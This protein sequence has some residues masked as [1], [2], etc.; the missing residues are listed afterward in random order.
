MKKMLFLSVAALAAV[1][2]IMSA[3]TKDN[4]PASV[5]DGSP[6]LV[7]VNGED[8]TADEFRSEAESLSP[9]A[10]QILA[11]EETKNKLLDNLVSRKLL[12]QQ[13]RKDGYE[14]DPEVVKRIGEVMDNLLLGYYVKREIFDKA[15]VSDQQVREYFDGSKDVLGSAR[16]S[17]IQVGSEE[18]AEE[19]IV[20]Y[21]SGASFNALAR[22]YS[23]DAKTKASGGDL[24]FLSWSQFGSAELRAAAFDT[25]LGEVGNVVKSS[26]AYHV[27]KVTD[28]KPAKAEDFDKL[29]D[30]LK[31]H[32]LERRK[33]EF[34][35]T[36]V[37]SLKSGAL[38]TRNELA[39]K[40]LSS[41]G[42]AAEPQ[43]LGR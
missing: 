31:E 14:K 42:Q 41:S 8:I 25:P 38:I 40:E 13:A 37:G 16:I 26:Y 29:R 11:D 15:E 36:R 33:Q 3:C 34:F 30:E 12:I 7:T 6:V 32:L 10:D 9:Y 20:K 17:H 28:R 43:P 23:Q 5:P 2:F 18:E 35:D 19:I 22:E 24:G 1:G 27:I 4:S 21:K 39:I